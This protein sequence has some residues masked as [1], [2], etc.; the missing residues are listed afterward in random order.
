VPDLIAHAQASDV[1]A[2]RTL[3]AGILADPYVYDDVAELVADAFYAPDTRLGWQAMTSLRRSGAPIEIGTVVA[4][5]RDLGSQTAE[6]DFRRWAD[7]VCGAGNEMW[8]AQRIYQRAQIRRVREACSELLRECTTAELQREEGCGDALAQRAAQLIGDIAQRRSTKRAKTFAELLHEVYDY[9]AS[10][11]GEE[12]WQS[13]LSGLHQ[14]VDRFSPGDLV[15][16]LARPSHGKTSLA[17]TFALDHTYASDKASVVFST[18]ERDRRFVRRFVASE[19]RVRKADLRRGGLS[20]E[21][22]ERVG[23]AVTA[24]EGQRIVIDPCE[25][26]TFQHIRTQCLRHA[27]RHPIG[28][29]VLDHAQR[30]RFA[31]VRERTQEVE[32]IARGAKQLAEELNATVF[33]LS[34]LPKERPNDSTES[35]RP[36]A[37]GGQHSSALDQEAD[38][39][40]G[41]WYRHKAP[42]GVDDTTEGVVEVEVLK[43]RDGRTGGRYLCAIDGARVYDGRDL[44]FAASMARYRERHCGGWS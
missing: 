6:A 28:C 15:L 34:Q 31:G 16:C 30:I 40:L 33:L 20:G 43:Q 10:E 27:R 38:I 3:L 4:R 22:L 19:A 17:T 39:T 9:A 21:Q 24:L 18:E 26:V 36:T 2:E 7:C 29:V 42:R 11:R 5:M 25:R 23:R 37:S 8:Y 1:D 13:S 41:L 35:S 12:G 14:Q 32:E 44:R